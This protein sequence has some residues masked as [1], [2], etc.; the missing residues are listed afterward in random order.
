MTH[1]QRSELV[2]LIAAP[3]LTSRLSIRS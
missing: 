2:D 1:R 3:R